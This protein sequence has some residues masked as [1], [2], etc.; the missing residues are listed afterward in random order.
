MCLCRVKC[1]PLFHD[2]L[3]WCLWLSDDNS[4]NESSSVIM[5]FWSLL[6]QW[7]Y[8]WDRWETRHILKTNSSGIARCKAILTINHRGSKFTVMFIPFIYRSTFISI[9]LR[10]CVVHIV[11]TSVFY[12]K[13]VL[14]L[15][16]CFAQS[17]QSILLYL[18]AFC[19][20]KKLWIKKSLAL[21]IL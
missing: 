11:Y 14:Q 2:Y 20:H 9:F 1:V 21:T 17:A 16:C 10:V 6:Q 12:S 18:A 13:L 15:H 8:I 5:L 19:L 3:Y 7:P 4:F